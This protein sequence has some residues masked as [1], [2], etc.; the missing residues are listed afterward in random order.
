MRCA[1]PPPSTIVIPPGAAEPLV[2]FLIDRL[3]AAWAALVEAPEPRAALRALDG[4]RPRAHVDPADAAAARD[5]RHCLA[6]LAGAAR[7]ALAAL[8]D[9]VEAIARERAVEGVDRQPGR[10]ERNL[11]ETSAAGLFLLLRAV[12]DSR[13]EALAER[14]GYPEPLGSRVSA[15]LAALGLRCAGADAEG[16]YLDPGLARW[17]GI[18]RRPP[19]RETLAAAFETADPEARH[20]FVQGLLETVFPPSMGGGLDLAHLPDPS[21]RRTGDRGAGRRQRR[22]AA[23]RDPAARGFGPACDVDMVGAVG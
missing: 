2:A 18:E 15:L 14:S 12:R 4:G 3:L 1:W 10:S 11:I 9:P 5:A 20:R 16:E 6:G 23:R 22:L 13:L 21:R 19:A 17:A 7:P 8:I